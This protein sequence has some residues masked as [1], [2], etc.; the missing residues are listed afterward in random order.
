MPSAAWFPF[1]GIFHHKL[2]NV[3][4][5]P[6]HGHLVV[7]GNFFRRWEGVHIFAGHGPCIGLPQ[8]FLVVFAILWGLLTHPLRFLARG[9]PETW[10]ELFVGSDQRCCYDSV[11]PFR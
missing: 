2:G 9:S 7:F 1:T 4:T 3:S 10:P 6:F 11:V 5:F 8:V